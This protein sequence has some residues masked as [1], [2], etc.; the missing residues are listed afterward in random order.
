MHSRTLILFLSLTLMSCGG[1]GDGESPT[2][3]P[4]NRAP[5]FTSAQTASVVENN[6]AAYQAAASDPDGDALTF[7]IDGGADA[8][9]FAITPAGA[10]S[11][12]AAPDYDLPGDANADNVY[13]VQ[14]R[15]SDG[16]AGVTQAVNITVTNSREGISVVR[17]GTGFSQPLYVAPIPGDTRVYVV[18]KG[19]DVYR[20]DP[21]DGSRTRV[22]DITDISTS[23]ERGLLGLAPYP[24][25]AASQRLFAVATAAN[26]NVQVR[27]YTLGQPNSSTN[28]D[29]VHDIPH[30]GADNHNGGW[31]GFGPDGHVYVAVGDGGGGGDPNNNAQNRNVRLGK[32]LRFAVGAGGNSYAPAPGNPFLAG[33]GDPYI[34]AIG[35][36]N[37]FRASFSGSTLL[38]GDVGQGAVEEIDMVTTAQPGL[39]FGWRFLEGTQPYTGTAPAG[40]TP[41]VAEYGHGS[42]TRQGRSV[43]GGYV[44]RGPVA[45]LQGQYVFGDFVSGNIWTL[46]FADLVAGQTLPASRFAVRNEDFAP[47][48]GTIANIASFGE[49]SAG[50]LFIVSIGGAIF[51][52]RPG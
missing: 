4:T 47:D 44:Y 28:Y 37:P 22:L 29:L 20:F 33:G 36:R 52:V 39:N 23:G 16:N 17:V 45:S 9:L 25:H 35:L 10:L 41:P 31:I 13:A 48:A 2:L 24:D 42:G 21:A 15:V 1:G 26:G 5:A 11:F 32:I 27:R 43:T 51:M 40:L 49:D 8:A 50:N 18:E 7:T 19:G 30:P 46:P 34:F 12:R 14:L 6:T 38:I 3:P